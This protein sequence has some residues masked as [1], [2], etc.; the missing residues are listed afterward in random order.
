M[1]LTRVIQRDRSKV[2]MDLQR[3]MDYN[4]KFLVHRYFVALLSNAIVLFWTELIIIMCMDFNLLAFL[5]HFFLQCPQLVHQ[6]MNYGNTQVPQPLCFWMS[7]SGPVPLFM[8]TCMYVC[9]LPF[10]HCGVGMG[11]FSILHPLCFQ[12]T[13]L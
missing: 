2:Q 4:N 9:F 6:G 3:R 13:W 12:I 10:Q 7:F 11:I 5:N 8:F 1:F